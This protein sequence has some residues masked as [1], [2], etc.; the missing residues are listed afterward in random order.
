MLSV[1]L[2]HDICTSGMRH[3]NLFLGTMLV[4]QIVNIEKLEISFLLMIKS[5][6]NRL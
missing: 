3:E 1:T 6:F 2:K 5:I 4:L